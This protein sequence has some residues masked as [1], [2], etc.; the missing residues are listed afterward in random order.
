MEFTNSPLVS[1]TCLSP[2]RYVNRK[3]KIDTITPHV[4]VGHLPLETIGSIFA[5]EKSRSSCNYAIDDGGKVGLYVEEKDGSWCSSS[6]SND[7]RAVTIEIA[8]DKTHPYAITDAALS[9]LILL[10]T[11][12]C[13][14]N[15]IPKLLWEANKSLVG[16]IDRQNISV[17]RWFANKACPGDYLFARL[18][19]VAGEVNKLLLPVATPNP[20]PI[21][22]PYQVRINTDVLRY[23]N[24]PG[25]NYIVVGQVRKGEKYTIVE[26]AFGIGSSKWG[27]LKSGAGW[28][29]L[30]YCALIRA[31]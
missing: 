6:E 9:G 20:G 29:A 16:K 14:R 17:H 26:E 30:D 21:K 8:C 4:V 19:Y 23:R 31:R 3:H 24:G 28:V 12:I 11:D 5:N 18:G 1:Y 7:R 22:P 2:N 10:C 13:K 15:E 25:I 27:K